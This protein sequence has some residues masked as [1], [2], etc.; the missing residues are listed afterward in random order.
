M[1]RP[2]ASEGSSAASVIRPGGQRRD[3]QRAARDPVVAPPDGEL[4]EVE[5]ADDEA[6]E[7][8]AEE[9]RRSDAIEQPLQRVRAAASVAAS[10][11][12][13][14]VPTV[15]TNEAPTVGVIQWRSTGASS[16]NHTARARSTSSATPAQF[17]PS[18]GQPGAEHG[19]AGD[20]GVAR[21]AC[22]GRARK[23]ARSRTARAG[24]STR[25]HHPDD[26]AT[27]S[28]SARASRW[29]SSD[30]S[31]ETI[32]VPIT[33]APEAGGTAVEEVLDSAGRGRAWPISGRSVAA[34]VEDV[35]AA[36]VLQRDAPGVHE[37]A[38][39]EQRP[40]RPGDD[41]V[42]LVDRAARWSPRA[43]SGSR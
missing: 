7:A 36:D 28:S 29:P 26:A 2:R 23:R 30:R 15:R 13:D 34:A 40:E 43:T 32:P 35:G 10:T 31:I 11:A 16:A 8:E 20:S 38:E 17:Q 4:P 12:S 9:E 39:R 33:T 3:R 19:R 41:R 37:P 27:S 18:S 22:A 6:V 14:S 25:E 5:A 42:E 1:H 24:R 21:R